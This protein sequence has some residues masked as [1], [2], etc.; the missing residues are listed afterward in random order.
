MGYIGN[1]W[2]PELKGNYADTTKHKVKREHVACYNG[3][4]TLT[5]ENNIWEPLKKT[6]K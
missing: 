5:Y 2:Q 3:G 1:K 4:F 6:K